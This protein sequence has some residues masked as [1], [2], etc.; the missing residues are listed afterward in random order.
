[1]ANNLQNRASR[2]G[3]Q[4]PHPP[5]FSPITVTLVT[6]GRIVPSSRSFHSG[7]APPS[8]KE[9]KLGHGAIA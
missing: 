1:M 3:R 4:P 7:A 2:G 9:P 6:D 5:F 8:A